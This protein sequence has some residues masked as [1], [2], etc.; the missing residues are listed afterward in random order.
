MILNDLNMIFNDFCTV[1]E[2]VGEGVPEGVP[3]ISPTNI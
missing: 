2:G 1:P 3:A